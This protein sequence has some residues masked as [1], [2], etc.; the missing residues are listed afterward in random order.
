MCYGRLAFDALVIAFQ[1]LQ[2]A[3]LSL[4]SFLEEHMSRRIVVAAAGGLY[5]P[6]HTLG[7]IGIFASF[8]PFCSLK[9]STNHKNDT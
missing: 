1:W 3:I 6:S 4:F 7:M 8:L 5:Q 2:L 9:E